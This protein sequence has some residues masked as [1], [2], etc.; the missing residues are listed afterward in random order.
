LGKDLILFGE[1]RATTDRAALKTLRRAGLCEVQVG[2]EALSTNLLKKI[3]KGT[4][5]LDNLEIMKH[6]EALSIVDNSNL[7]LHFPGSDETDVEQ[8]LRTVEFARFFRP[9]RIVYFWLGL[10]SPVYCKPKAYGLKAVFNHP[11]Y[12]VLFPSETTERIKFMIQD[13]RGDKTLQRKLWKP[14]EEAV[15]RWRREYETL[16]EKPG[17]GPILGYRDGRDFMI[18]RRRRI[19]A[20]PENHR[21]AGTSRQIYLFCEHARSKKEIFDRFPTF[22]EDKILAFLDTMVQKRLMYGE[23]E[24]YLSLAVPDVSNPTE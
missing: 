9:L 16:H 23:N 24:K 13:Y 3:N 11:N 17:A 8:S 7:L 18:L 21:L 4:T 15:V 12:N 22:A 2:V 10:E 6:C 19:G 20:K 14:V 5:V 1:L